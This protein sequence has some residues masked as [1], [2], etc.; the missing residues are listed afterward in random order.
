MM[1]KI[2][3]EELEVFA[4]HGVFPE[5]NRLGQKFVLSME[6]Y[7]DLSKAGRTDD[8]T[9]SVNYGEVCA[10]CTEWM[11]QH[12][13]QLIE[14]A[15]EQL[16]QSVLLTY[17][18]IDSIVLAIRKPWAPVGLPLKSV[19]VSIRRGWHR[20][21]IALGSN[22]GDKAKYLQDALDALERHEAI[23]VC[24]TADFI[25]TAPYGGVEQ[26]DFL[27]SA[28]EVRTLLPPLALLDVMQRI[29]CD[30]KRERLIHWGPRTL[31]LDLLF[32]D[33]LVLDSERLNVPHPEIPKRAFVLD[34]MVQLAPHF[35]HPYLH[36]T[37]QQ[38]REELG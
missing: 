14:T 3:I 6:L 31:D 26:D 9:Q 36:K 30:A 22:M 21:F 34:P 29:E 5:E 15:A 38:L 13:V 1:D 18:L 4:R 33:D 16:A 11:H 10:F 24:R 2:V 25:T 17:P 20:A 32:Y 8:L 35:V 12:T 27:N 37:M 19:G 7:L 28:V 23:Q